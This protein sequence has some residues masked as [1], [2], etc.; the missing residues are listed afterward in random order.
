MRR[1]IQV[2]LMATVP[3]A[4]LLTAFVS[5][6]AGSGS[7]PHPCNPG[8]PENCT[9]TPIPPTATLTPVPPT[10]TD[11]SVPPTPTPK[12]VTICH[13][14]NGEP[15]WK[16]IEVSES[17]VDA[18]L[19]HGDYLGACNTPT[20]EPTATETP[21]PTDT[22]EPTATNTPEPTATEVL[23]TDTPL[24]TAT[25]VPPTDTPQPTATVVPPTSTP[26]TVPTIRHRKHTATPTEVVVVPT[27]APPIVVAPVIPPVQVIPSVP[28][29]LPSTGEGADMG[30]AVKWML[31]TSGLMFCAGW[32]FLATAYLVS[33]ERK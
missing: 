33:R 2:L 31:Y 9:P 8:H 19:A 25:A 3:L 20:P 28:V 18:H 10:P 26:T 6:A 7:G 22:P 16:T 27:V 12:K 21:M 32:L 23:P 1:W 11:T 29:T 15:E 24:P 13:R 30:L 17:A 4:V 5:T 14:D